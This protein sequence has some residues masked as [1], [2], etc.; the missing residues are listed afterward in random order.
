MAQS[1][2]ELYIH[3]IFHVNNNRCLV[4][5]EDERELY[6]NIGSLIKI[7]KSIPFTINRT[8]SFG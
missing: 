7:S 5:P 1:L 2:S 8:D 6:A 4:M 3:T